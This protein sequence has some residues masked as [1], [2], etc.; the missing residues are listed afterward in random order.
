MSEP[1]LPERRLEAPAASRRAATSMVATRSGR[2]P[3]R[4][5]AS[6]C[7]ARA[8]AARIRNGRDISRPIQIAI[9]EALTGAKPAA[10]ALKDA[11]QEDRSR[12]SP[13]R[14]CEHA[15]AVERAGS[16]APAARGHARPGRR[17]RGRSA[18]IAAAVR[19]PADAGRSICW[20]LIGF[21]I[22]YNLLMS[23][24]EVNL[25]N[26]AT[27]ARPF[28]GLDNYARR[29]APTRRSARCSSTRC[30]FVV[31]QRRSARSG[32]AARRRVVFFAQRFPARISCA[33][34]C[35]STW[36]LP[37][38]VVGAVWKWLFATAIRRRQLRAVGPRADQQR[39]CTGCPIPSLALTSVTI[40][41]HLV[42][43]AVQHDPDRGGA[44]QHPG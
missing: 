28:V 25:G 10:A 15:R 9:Q 40:S 36:M 34:C 7:R 37:A 4:S 42:R 18:A 1:E 24:Q 16:P 12:S 2:R 23:L 44:H 27:L 39:R 38:L 32:S 3:M 30:V 14:R 17:M 41:Q 33:A 35:W 22:V 43:H 21:P 8:R 19:L 26:I 11:A 31:A 5:S 29:A 20:R 6:R 13:T